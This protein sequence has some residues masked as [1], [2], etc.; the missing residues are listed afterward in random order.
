MHIVV[1]LCTGLLCRRRRWESAHRE[2]KEAL[3]TARA[4]ATPRS[5]H[6]GAPSR[7]RLDR[8]KPNTIRTSFTRFFDLHLRQ[9]CRHT[10]DP[11]KIS[12]ILMECERSRGATTGQGKR[13]RLSGF[14]RGQ[15]GWWSRSE[16]RSASAKM[17]GLRP[18][19]SRQRGRLHAVA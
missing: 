18:P 1:H 2:E 3:C 14:T 11:R 19:G 12:S 7:M 9:D 8:F 5:A 10:H 15:M 6:S 13:W 16:R 17:A 4:L